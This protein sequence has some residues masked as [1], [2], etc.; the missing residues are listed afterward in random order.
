MDKASHGNNMVLTRKTMRYSIKIVPVNPEAAKPPMYT[1]Q[2]EEISMRGVSSLAD[3][4]EKLVDSLN[5]ELFSEDIE[6]SDALFDKVDESMLFAES[7]DEDAEE[8]GC[9]HCGR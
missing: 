2:V 7:G 3:L 5:R 6:I 1:V 9:P 4:D 8:D